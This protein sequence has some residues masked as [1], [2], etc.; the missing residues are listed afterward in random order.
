MDVFVFC[1][2]FFGFHM[3]RQHLYNLDM[4]EKKKF[5]L[6]K[7]LVCGAKEEQRQ[8]DVRH[9]SEY[10]LMIPHSKTTLL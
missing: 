10:S 6:K 1:W 4:E 8:S 7:L 2:V 5:G 9:V 3:S